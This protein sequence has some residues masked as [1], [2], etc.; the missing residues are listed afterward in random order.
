CFIALLRGSYLGAAESPA[1]GS[2]P[3]IAGFGTW[4]LDEAPFGAS[5]CAGPTT[6][7]RAGKIGDAEAGF[8]R[9]AQILACSRVSQTRV[10]MRGAALVSGL[11]G[12]ATI[13]RCCCHARAS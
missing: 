11:T 13:A 3:A 4:T 7:R 5:V 2:A 8:R 12:S 1:R 9:R 6:R 10:R